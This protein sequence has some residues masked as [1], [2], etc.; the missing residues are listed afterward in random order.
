MHRKSLVNGAQREAAAPVVLAHGASKVNR[1]T[2]VARSC[3]S[4]HTLPGPKRTTLL[5]RVLGQDGP[6]LCVPC[7]RK[8][9]LREGSTWPATPT[10]PAGALHSPVSLLAVTALAVLV[11]ADHILYFGVWR[12]RAG[13]GGANAADTSSLDSNCFHAPQHPW[14]REIQPSPALPP[15]PDG[16]P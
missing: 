2:S 16:H 14:D 4:S 7:Q 15:K 13:P 5:P 3:T 10:C 1:A 8:P 11:T 9:R 6:H 12:A